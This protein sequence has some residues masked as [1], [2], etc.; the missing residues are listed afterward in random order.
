MAMP[1]LKLQLLDEQE[2]GVGVGVG[3]GG[4]FEPGQAA[5]VVYSKLYV[6]VGNSDTVLD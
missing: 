1:G 6:N 3:S 5:G 4:G 2:V